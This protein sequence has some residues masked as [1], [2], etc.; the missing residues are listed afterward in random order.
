MPR[1]LKVLWARVLGLI[2]RV[3]LLGFVKS[4]DA[5][6]TNK[7][8]QQIPILTCKAQR[9]SSG[10]NLAMYLPNYHEESHVW[11]FCF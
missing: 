9:D 11:L 2:D 8:K 5:I 4:M 7:Y 3:L 6:Y 10:K 1:N